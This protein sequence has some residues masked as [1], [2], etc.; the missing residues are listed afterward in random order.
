MKLSKARLQA[1]IREELFYRE[2]YKTTK[3]SPIK[4]P[5]NEENADPGGVSEDMR[6]LSA[7]IMNRVTDP[8]DLNDLIGLLQG[9]HL[10]ATS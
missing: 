1:I 9:E 7:E 10:E 4:L 8:K 3:K 2:F 5:I 6:A